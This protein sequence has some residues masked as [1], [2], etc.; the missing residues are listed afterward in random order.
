MRYPTPRTVEDA[1]DNISR[2]ER[3]ILDALACHGRDAVMPFTSKELSIFTFVEEPTARFCDDLEIISLDI[4]VRKLAE[5]KKMR[6][7][8]PRARL[9]M[10][11]DE[12][13]NVVARGRHAV[14]EIVCRHNDPKMQAEFARFVLSA[15]EWGFD[16]VHKMPFNGVDAGA[17]FLRNRKTGQDTQLRDWDDSYVLLDKLV[18]EL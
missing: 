6:P 4:A 8:L 1:D 2:M 16:V 11:R 7:G 13:R 10:A 14:M 17:S 5:W 3:H 9:F 15:N 18:R 12:R